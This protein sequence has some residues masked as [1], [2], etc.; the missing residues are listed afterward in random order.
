MKRTYLGSNAASPG[1]PYGMWN[2]SWGGDTPGS[3]SSMLALDSVY[4]N[5]FSITSVSALVTLSP[6][7]DGAPGEGGDP[8]GVH[9][10]VTLPTTVPALTVAGGVT[11][12]S[13]DGT[14]S[15]LAYN[16]DAP[17]VCNPGGSAY[18]TGL[19][20]GTQVGT[21]LF[22]SVAGPNDGATVSSLAG[23]IFWVTA[24]LYTLTG[25]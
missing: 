16:D 9:A 19:V 8:F 24:E 4:W 1:T 21:D 15:L 2:L 23:G 5:T 10:D 12:T 25:L 20:A 3:S 22:L 17:T 14:E 11:V 7:V 6:Q 18:L 13:L